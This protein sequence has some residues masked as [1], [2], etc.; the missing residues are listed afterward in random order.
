[1]PSSDTA[2]VNPALIA[3][4][5]DHVSRLEASAL[6][7]LRDLIRTPSVSG[8]EGDHLDQQSVAGRLWTSLA[9]VPGIERF[10]DPVFPARD[11]V[12]AVIPGDRER[13]FVLDA[14]TDTV[15]AGDPA[16]WLD[17]GPHAA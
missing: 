17:G 16:A 6:E 15:P 9:D 1:M 11:N 2:D 3:D 12:M 8:Q 14:H 5:T 13:V 7:V 10:A 4:I